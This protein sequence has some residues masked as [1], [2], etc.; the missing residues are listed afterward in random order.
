MKERNIGLDILRA[1]AIILVVLGHGNHLFPKEIRSYTALPHYIDGVSIFFVLS[2]FLIGG[3]IINK[4]LIKDKLSFL[5]LKEFLLRRWYRTLPLYFIILTLEIALYF[6]EWNFDF[7]FFFFLQNLYYPQSN[8]FPVSWSLSVEE[9]FYL[10][11]PSVLFIISIFTRITQKKF[12]FTILFFLF[13]PILLRSLIFQNNNEII[14][15]DREIRKVVLYRFDSIMYGV[16]L[17]YIFKFKKEILQNNKYKFLIISIILSFILFLNH[18]K[19]W[20]GIYYLDLTIL[21][22]ESY[23]FIFKFNVESM[24]VFFLIPYLFFLNLNKYSILIKII[25]FISKVSY[26][27][28]LFHGIVLWFIIPYF[29]GLLMKLNMRF[30]LLY[31]IEIFLYIILSIF[32]SYLSYVFIELKFLN[33]RDKKIMP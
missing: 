25:T 30:E 32:L 10:V 22:S 15:F 2:G 23:K 33:I 24:V 21:N 16:L 12:L 19:S 14:N 18:L 3:I 7:T 6:D 31:L 8:F 20:F 1:W 13:V 17:A 28:Y 27:L 11:F 26:S 29:H 4:F 5:N 9:W